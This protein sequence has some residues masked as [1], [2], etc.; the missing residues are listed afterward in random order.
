M[1]WS[2]LEMINCGNIWYSISRAIL[3]F[4]DGGILTRYTMWAFDSEE[5]DGSILTYAA[6]VFG[7]KLM[8]GNSFMLPW[9]PV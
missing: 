8:V 2:S 6:N 9:L 5:G 4:L 1:L 7:A 3:A